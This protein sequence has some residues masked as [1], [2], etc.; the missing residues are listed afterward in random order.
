MSVIVCL[1]LRKLFLF[2]TIEHNANKT[3]IINTALSFN[4]R[5]K[6]YLI[7]SYVFDK[8]ALIIFVLFMLCSM[9]PN[10]NNFHKNK[11]TMTHIQCLIIV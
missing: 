11:E 1:F 7:L 2:G 8:A 4:L 3:N 9:V 5:C 10:K 6:R